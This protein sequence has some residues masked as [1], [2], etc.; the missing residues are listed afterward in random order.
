MDFAQ[1]KKKKKG[2]GRSKMGSVEQGSDRECVETVWAVPHYPVVTQG[3]VLAT[4]I[5]I[6][7]SLQRFPQRR[8][9]RTNSLSVGTEYL[10]A[11]AK[12]LGNYLTNVN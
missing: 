7:G 12:Y 11:A 3:R 8:V 6:I 9:P 1:C 10:Q 5:I 4:L 2:N